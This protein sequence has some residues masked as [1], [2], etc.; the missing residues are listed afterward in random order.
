MLDARNAEEAIGRAFGLG[1]IHGARQPMT[2]V[3]R[4]PEQPLVTFRS[5][6]RLLVD[7]LSERQL[8]AR[9]NSKV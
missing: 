1:T 2:D 7:G 3:F 5:C 4:A 6:F 9:V 8:G